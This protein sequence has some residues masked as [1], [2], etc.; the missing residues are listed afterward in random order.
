MGTI[1]ILP[2]NSTKHR[3]Y[4]CGNICDCEPLDN[5]CQYC[6]DCWRP[7]LEYVEQI[8]LEY[9]DGKE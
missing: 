2:H 5:E 3:C 1:P 6:D 9:E 4:N 8:D 7:V